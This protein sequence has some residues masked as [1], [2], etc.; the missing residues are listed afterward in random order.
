MSPYASG[1]EVTVERSKAE[2]ER[3][4]QRYGA[5]QFF[6]AWDTD[7]RAMV[8]FTME[9]R[10]VKL[11]LP[12]PDKADDEF[13]FYPVNA[14]GT[15]RERE[16]HR[17]HAA[18]EQACRSR[19]RALR[20]VVQAKLEAVECGISTFEREFMADVVMSDGKTVGQWL[21]PQLA[22]MYETKR[23]PNLLPGIGK[24]GKSS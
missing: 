24:T 20:L 19:W 6:S 9:G 3:L 22:E 15:R 1:S 13:R 2:I 10:M 18:W 5:S 8:G 11:S 7:G 21:Q 23:M 17:V 14:Y 12:L 16:P 4:V